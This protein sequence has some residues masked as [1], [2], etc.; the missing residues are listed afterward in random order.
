MDTAGHGQNWHAHSRVQ[1][2]WFMD[3]AGQAHTGMYTKAHKKRQGNTNSSR[4]WKSA[5]CSAEA[6]I[7]D[8]GASQYQVPEHPPNS[9]MKHSNRGKDSEQPFTRGHRLLAQQGHGEAGTHLHPGRVQEESS[10]SSPA[11]RGVR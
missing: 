5:G 9:G 2:H 8:R 11:A 4:S 6:S 3:T 10:R 7:L 1:A